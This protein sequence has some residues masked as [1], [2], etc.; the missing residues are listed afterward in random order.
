MRLVVIGD[1]A[2]STG[3]E[4]TVCGRTLVGLVRLLNAAIVEG[5]RRSREGGPTGILRRCGMRISRSP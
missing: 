3:T 1:D 2:E 4:G 5:P